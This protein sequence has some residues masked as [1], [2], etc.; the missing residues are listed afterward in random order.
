MPTCAEARDDVLPLVHFICFLAGHDF[1][2]VS[3]TH[4]KCALLRRIS[5]QRL[6]DTT[7]RWV[8][9]EHDGYLHS[10]YFRGGGSSCKGCYWGVDL[11]PF[12]TIFVHH[13]TSPHFVHGV[14]APVTPHS[15]AN[16]QHSSRK[17][18]LRA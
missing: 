11:S 12:E 14:R 15:I 18:W 10:G 8:D 3:A 5:S 13:Y 17:Q 16:T 9:Y 4:A 2:N 6:N 1:R 7:D